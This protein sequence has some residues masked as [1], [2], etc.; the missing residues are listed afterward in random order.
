MTLEYTS[1]KLYRNSQ[2]EIL[3]WEDLAD[4]KKTAV[5][6]SA[7]EIEVA[8][9]LYKTII[10]DEIKKNI[11]IF[12]EEEQAAI[13]IRLGVYDYDE[14]SQISEKTKGILHNNKEKII[15]LGRKVLDD[16][17]KNPSLYKKMWVFH[18]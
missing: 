16:I 17:K 14:L 3:L 12:P 8:R 2:G 11:S 6:A 7:E 10:T 4:E 13:I 9:K 5:E 18:Q 15:K 1:P